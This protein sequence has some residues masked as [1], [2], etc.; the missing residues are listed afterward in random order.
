MAH[1]AILAI[2]VVLPLL[3]APGA[4]AA[5]SEFFGITQGFLDAQDRQQL[6]S[7]KVRTARFLLKWRTLEPTRGTYDWTQRDHFIGALASHGIRTVPFLWGSPEWVGAGRLAQP[8]VSELDKQAW[9]QFVR[10]AVSRYGPGGTYWTNI[11]PQQFPGATPLPITS[12]Q[13]WNEPNLQKY[14]SPGETVQQSARKYAGLLQT[15]HDAI[16]AVDPNARVVLAGMPGSGDSTA[17]TFLNNLYTVPGIRDDFDAA[18]FHPYSCTVP[19]IAQE[20]SMFRRSMTSHGDGQTPL[21]VTEFAWGSGPPDR[22]CKNKNLAGQRDLLGRAF[23]LFIAGRR[24]WNLQ[25]LFWFMW[26]DP[27]ATSP[28][29]SLCS[30]CGTAGLFRND[31]TPKPAYSMFRSFT[32]ETVAPI[33]RISSGP[34]FG[35]TIRNRTPKFSFVS[36]D[37]GAAFQCGMDDDPLQS[38]P[39]SYSPRPL[40]DG[41]HSLS[42]RAVD[43]AGNVSET[44]SRSFTVDTTAPKATITAGPPEGSTSGARTPTFRFAS[45]EPDVTFSCRLDAAGFA[46]CSSPYTTP[47]LADGE[48]S[49][50][51]RAIDQA[52]NLGQPATRSWRV[53]LAIAGGPSPGSATNDPTP[54]FSFSSPDGGGF[55]CSIDG[56]APQA[57]TSPYT[58][59]SLSEGDHTFTVRQGAAS[60]SRN[61][62]VDTTPPPVALTSGPANGSAINDP[63]PTFRFSSSEPRVSFECRY[64]RQ[65]FSACSDPRSD[66]P[67]SPL[68]D[69]LQTF[70]VRAV[71]VAHN[72]SEPLLRSFTVDTVPPRVTIQRR[73]KTGSP[74]RKARATF[75]LEAS[76]QVRRQCRVD[77][78]PFR[79]CS[80]RYTTPRLRAG[81]H[82]LKVKVTDRA[83]NVSAVGGWFRIG[84]KHSRITT[85]GE[86]TRATCRGLA[87]TVIGSPGDDRLVG[88][89]GRDVIVPLGGDDVVDARG[90]RD[91]VCAKYGQDDVTTGPGADWVRGG[92]GRDELHGGRGHDTIRGGTGAD[93]CGSDPRDVTLHC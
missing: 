83:G 89:S 16:V 24:A 74:N 13:V 41:A 47:T 35:T 62:T 23:R 1:A 82:Q 57:C 70:R 30:I 85:P 56:A 67:G 15:T 91:V 60:A 55:T 76:E 64:E 79:H 66:T 18:A 7:T 75:F 87:A 19:Q 68:R 59:P 86:P 44:R 92:P 2:A 45:T 48:H 51:V 40:A 71:D 22:F 49:F 53:G 58:A 28:Y 93:V 21:W 39:T 90:G 17:W 25:R 52:G 34:P 54:S 81:R 36:D 31:R 4:Q 29:A 6:E 80:W 14:F 38:C 73:G 42:V 9:R 11:F 32:A 46:P 78:R 5:R 43:A 88:T 37:P 8:P 27:A 50:H 3:A 77:A 69:G 72:A 10:A 65:G 61:F 20:M 33:V 26:R 12:W 63:T 84:K